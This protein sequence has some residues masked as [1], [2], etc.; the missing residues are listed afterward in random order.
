MY[1]NFSEVSILSGH[2]VDDLILL[3]GHNPMPNYLTACML[4]PRRVHWLYT[5]ETKLECNRLDEALKREFP[6]LETKSYHL[7][8]AT[9]P[10]ETQRAMKD[11]PEGAWLNYTGGTKAMTVHAYTY[12]RKH[13]GGQVERASYFDGLRGILRYDHGTD[14]AVSASLIPLTIEQMMRLHGLERDNELTV[15]DAADIR[16][17]DKQN[18]LDAV[19]EDPVLNNPDNNKEPSL[20]DKLYSCCKPLRDGKAPEP[21]RL[22]FLPEA[23]RPV[24][25]QQAGWPAV[26]GKSRK[27]KEA[28][29]KFLTG[30]WFENWVEDVVR[31][32]CRE[33]GLEQVQIESGVRPRT[34]RQTELDL[35]LLDGYHVSL[36][37]C[38]TA[39]KVAEVKAKCYEARNRVELVGGDLARAAVVSLLHESKVFNVEQSVKVPWQPDITAVKV[40]G[41]EDVR[42]WRVHGDCS[43]LISWLKDGRR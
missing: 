15:P 36:I 24:F 37:S 43:G 29:G 30:D 5:T 1:I 32:A 35:I 26:D 28:W 16:A 21:I 11:M 33:A 22:E 23:A 4:R 14:E 19:L 7:A 17:E 20:V 40:F 27:V 39:R 34:Q 38:T 2:S 9:S 12:W 6:D 18:L 42:E 8:D 31:E 25:T 3:V 41:I 13:L 10:F